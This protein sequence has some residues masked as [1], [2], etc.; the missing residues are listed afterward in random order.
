MVVSR[1]VEIL[2]YRGFGRQRGRGFG[3]LPQVIGRTAI[4]L[5]PKYIAMLLTSGSLLHKRLEKL[6]AVKIFQDGCKECG[7]ANSEKTSW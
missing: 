6:L 3:A 4:P 2:Y 1:Q 7:K 5:L